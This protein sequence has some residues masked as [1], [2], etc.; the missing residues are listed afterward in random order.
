LKEKVRKLRQGRAGPGEIHPD[1][2]VDT[3]DHE[4]H[5]KRA[6]VTDITKLKACVWFIDSGVS[7]HLCC[8]YFSFD[9]IAY[10]AQPMKIY[11][12]DNR[13]VLAAGRGTITGCSTLSP[14]L[15]VP[16]LK[17]NFI[18]VGQLIKS[19]YV[20]AFMRE[21][22]LIK[23]ENK[24]VLK[25]QYQNGM[26]QLLLQDE[27]VTMQEHQALQTTKA[28]G[29]LPLRTWHRWLGHLNVDDIRK[30]A[31]ESA[32][33][34]YINEDHDKTDICIPCLQGKRHMN[35]NR[36]PAERVQLGSLIHS[37][38]CGSIATPSHSG[39]RY[40]II[41]VDDWSQYIWVYFLQSKTD[42][43]PM[44][45]WEFQVLL[46]TQCSEARIQRFRSLSDNGTGEYNNSIFQ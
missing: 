43:I 18:F 36:K 13:Y 32:I 41:Y 30:I 11:M 46:E 39:Y 29:S 26:Y 9:E 31:N 28:T 5:W 22:C 20:V 1:P 38:L 23:K 34:I 40:F 37:D 6:L 16:W 42:E 27:P 15:Y 33:D 19:G 44:K 3:Q 14:A 35:I 12:S 10:F 7:G 17:V 24:E 45:F 21:Y 4:V 2:I 25:A 8:D